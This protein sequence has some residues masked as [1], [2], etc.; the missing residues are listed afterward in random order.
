[1]KALI[2]MASP[3]RQGN[4]AALLVPFQAQLQQLGWE[5]ETVRLYDLRIDPCRGCRTC[6]KERSTFG[7]PLEDDAGALAEKSLASQ[8]LVL[9]SPIYSW[10]CTAPLKAL[11][12]RFVYGMN[13]FYGGEKGPS[14]WEGKAVAAVSTCGYP[15]ERGSDL[16][17]EGLVRYCR[18]S[19]LH[20]L[21]MLTERHKSY[22]LPFMDDQKAE[23]ARSFAREIAGK[24]ERLANE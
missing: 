8:L 23:R 2:L 16:W 13:K 11:L 4:T 1:M 15:P 9:A 7:C 22:D 19:H 17:Q 18:H 12:D 21:G 20:F 24:A 6:Q 3:R 14:L 10:Y 5:T